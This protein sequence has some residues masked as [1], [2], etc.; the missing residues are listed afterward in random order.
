MCQSEANNKALSSALLQTLSG[1]MGAVVPIAAG[2]AMN[3]SCFFF[4]FSKGSFTILKKKKKDVSALFV[5]VVGAASL[6]IGIIY[7]II[8]IPNFPHTSLLYLKGPTILKK[9]GIIFPFIFLEAFAGVIL[10]VI[11]QIGSF[12]LI[13]T[14]ALFGLTFLAPSLFV[15]LIPSFP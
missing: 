14:P 11:L 4:E 6:A 9:A 3:V 5:Y 13:S 15:S 2:Y 12:R 8:F 1:F 7:I 10:S